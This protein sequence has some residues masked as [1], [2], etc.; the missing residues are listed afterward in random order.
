MNDK[1]GGNRGLWDAGALAV[2]VLV[3]LLT[4]GCIVHISLGPSAASTARPPYRAELAYAQCMRTHGLPGFPDPSP[5]GSFSWQLTGNPATPAAR[6]NDTCRHLLA[7]GSTGPGSAT[8]PATVTPRRG[9]SRSAGPAPA[10][11]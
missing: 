6:T 9:S 4:A 8:A 5:S 1:T 10:R 2:A 7:G 3:T 11:R